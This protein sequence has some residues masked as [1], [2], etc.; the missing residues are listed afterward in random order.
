VNDLRLLAE[1]SQKRLEIVEV[2]MLAEQDRQRKEA[3]EKKDAR[4]PW[5]QAGIGLLEKF[6]WL[7]L[8]GGL[9]WLWALRTVS[10]PK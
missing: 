2:W 3:Q 1:T 10:T 4:K 5:Q 7:A 8:T 6:V 9:A